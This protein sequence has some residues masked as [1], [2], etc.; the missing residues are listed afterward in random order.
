MDGIL[1]VYATVFHRISKGNI[2][3]STA[4]WP[5]ERKRNRQ[6][7]VGHLAEGRHR[8]QICRTRFDQNRTNRSEAK[9]GQTN[10][11]HRQGAE[12]CR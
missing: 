5:T 7:R 9:C 6:R 12:T 2:H 4:G 1:N 10:G 3:P 11:L 8:F